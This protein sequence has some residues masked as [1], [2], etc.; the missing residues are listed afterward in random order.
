MR[1]RDVMGHSAE[2]MRFMSPSITI[3]KTPFQYS[4]LN[5]S[6][7]TNGTPDNKSIKECGRLRIK[8]KLLFEQLIPMYTC[9]V[10]CFMF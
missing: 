2:T 10:A 8:L 9:Y 6:S 3:Y 5:L 7:T 1:I 4:I